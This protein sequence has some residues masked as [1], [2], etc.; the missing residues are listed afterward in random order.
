MPLMNLTK[1][2]IIDC[3][4]DFHVHIDGGRSTLPNAYR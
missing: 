1:T 3:A 4:I 2:L